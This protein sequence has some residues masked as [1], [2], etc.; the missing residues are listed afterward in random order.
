MVHDPSPKR[1]HISCEYGNEFAIAEKIIQTGKTRGGHRA[2]ASNPSFADMSTN[3]QS[4]AKDG[5]DVTIAVSDDGMQAVVAAYTP[6]APDGPPLSAD[7]LSRRMREAG[8]AETENPEAEKILLRARLGKDV[9]GM[10]VARGRAP[11]EPRD[12]EVEFLGDMA[13]PVFRGDVF[14][15]LTP[16]SK[17]TPGATVTGAP[18]LPV[19]DRKPL[20]VA[21][22]EASGCVLDP[23]TQEIQAARYGLVDYRQRTLNIKPLL[24]VAEDNLLTTGTVYPKNFLGAPLTDDMFNRELWAMG[25]RTMARKE[26]GK[27]LAQAAATG[28]PVEGTVLAKGRPPQHGKDGR[29]DILFTGEEDAPDADAMED[30]DPRERSIFKPIKEG[31]LIG[32]LQPPSEGRFGRDVYGEDLVPRKG[33]PMQITAGDNVVVS[34]DGVEFKAAISGMITWTGNRVSVLEMVRVSGNVSY[35]TG[36]LRLDTGSVLIDGSVN[37]GF[38]VTAPGD[39][40]VAGAVERAVIEA[41]G[42]VGVG[43]GLIMGG[44]GHVHARGDVACAFAENATVACGGDLTV[45]QHLTTSDVR[46]GGR[47]R[48]VRGKGLIM[49]GCVQAGRGVEANEIGSEFGVKTHV[50]LDP[51][52]K[53]GGVKKLVLERKE[54]RDK[55]SQL[56]AVLGTEAPRAVLERTP[57]AKR[58]EAAELLK[59]RIAVVHRLG[60]LEQALK[61]RREALERIGSMKIKVLRTAHPGVVVAIADKKMV[62]HEAAGPCEFFY[63]PETETVAMRVKS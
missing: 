59:A 16:A 46:A 61:E 49:G 12:A 19:S 14:A 62:L 33:R 3:K 31:T 39:V 32:R 48:C 38:S 26:L 55:K 25:L 43:G 28:E 24:K 29:F 47:I 37:D 56:D 45:I 36:N 40:S 60:E 50:S 34:E 6:P 22:D 10:T 18:V 11:R 63:D 57:P 23:E 41:Q 1:K 8:I 5:A 58:A 52:I 44:E 20:D 4:T 7:I 13:C 15:R 27:A 42:N 35:A 51:G 53:V 30:I 9:T 17:P 2:D 21:C 54:L